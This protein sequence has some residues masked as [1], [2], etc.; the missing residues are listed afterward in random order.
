[1]TYGNRIRAILS[2]DNNLVG[3][4]DR[5]RIYTRG[6]VDKIIGLFMD[7]QFVCEEE[8]WPNNAGA[9]CFISWIDERGELCCT[10]INILY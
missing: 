4:E 8:P 7:T 6:T 1:M 2:N 9:A 3:I 10:V 5:V